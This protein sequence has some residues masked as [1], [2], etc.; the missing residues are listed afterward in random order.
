MKLHI[1]IFR[2][3]QTTFNRDAR[4]TGFIDAPLTKTGRDDARIV[5]LRLKKKKINAAFCTRLKRSRESLK[6]VLKFHSGCK[7]IICDDRMIERG[8]GNLAGKTHFEVVKKYGFE[9]YD[10]WHRGFN[11][12]PSSGESFAD[13]EKRVRE[14]IR[15]LIA[16]VKKEK[17]N[18]V[19]SAHGNSIRLFRKIM[20]RANE[21]ETVEWFIPYDN[22]YE[23][24]INV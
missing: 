9:S 16:F 11:S 10:K 23:Y 20:E 1:Y 4:F 7:R 19:I 17:V 18:V 3:G 24:V 22:Y 6:E 8:Y 21:K 13:V 5:A 15:D 2:H 12:R 14:F